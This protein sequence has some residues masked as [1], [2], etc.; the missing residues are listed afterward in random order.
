MTVKKFINQ[1]DF[2]CNVFI[3]SDSKSSFIIDLGYYDEEIEKYISTTPPVKFI[4][5]THG[6]FDHILGL[7]EFVQKNPD[8]PVYIHEKELEV[9][10]DDYKNC[11]SS[12]N[13]KSFIPAFSFKTFTEGTLNLEDFSFNIIHTPGHTQGSCIFYLKQEKLLFTGDTIIETSIGRTDLPTGNEREL[14]K[15]L[16][17]IKKLTIDDEV[18][19]FFGHGQDFIF[20]DLIKYNDFLTSAS[21]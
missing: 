11:S 7:N 12:M 1:K 16:E 17:K 4:L 19:V 14:I 21:F 5:Q 6:H 8:I 9:V 18:K 13:M 15:S 3:C 2:S 20:K 10:L